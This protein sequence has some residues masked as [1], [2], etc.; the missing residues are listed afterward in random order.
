[1]AERARGAERAE[2]RAKHR[3]DGLALCVAVLGRRPPP[4]LRGA[5]FHTVT[6]ANEALPP[7]PP[8]PLPPP[9]V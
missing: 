6:A 3:D 5:Y 7:S 9:G 2:K 1:M 8:A 4:P